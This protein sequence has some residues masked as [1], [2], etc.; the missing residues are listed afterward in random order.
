MWRI[1]RLAEGRRIAGGRSP[2]GVPRLQAFTP[3]IRWRTGRM[4]GPLVAKSDK[5]PGRIFV[6]RFL[7]AHYV[8][9]FSNCLSLSIAGQTGI[10]KKG[11]AEIP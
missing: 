2:C 5:T 3:R 1:L 9:Y 8:A 11:L 10:T 4:S 7:C 6:R